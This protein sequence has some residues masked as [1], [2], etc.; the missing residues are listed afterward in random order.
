MSRTLIKLFLNNKNSNKIKKKI[1]LIG[2]KILNDTYKE[3]GLLLK[4]EI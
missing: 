2:N 3:I 1:N 4:N